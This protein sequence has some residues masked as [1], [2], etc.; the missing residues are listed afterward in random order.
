IEPEGSQGFDKETKGLKAV[1]KKIEEFMSTIE[2]SYGNEVSEPVVGGNS[3]AFSLD[4]DIKMKGQD[5]MN[6][7]EICVY[8]VKDGKII[9]EQFYW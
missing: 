7:K 6:M 2:E 5:R 4:M 1:N 9:L 3:F 8:T